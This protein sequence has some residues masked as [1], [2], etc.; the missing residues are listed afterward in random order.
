MQQLQRR[1]QPQH[2]RV[3]RVLAG[4]GNGTPTPVRE[5]RA[6]P[7]TAAQHELFERGGQFRVIRADISGIAATTAE[8]LPQL[9]G[10][11]A[12]QLDG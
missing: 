10:D 8:V 9:I 2:R 12:R 5:R 11:G 7:F 6:Q 1:E 3:N 4:I